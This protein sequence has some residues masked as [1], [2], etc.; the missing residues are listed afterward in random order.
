MVASTTSCAISKTGSDQTV[1]YRGSII[2]MYYNRQAV[3]TYKDAATT[4]YRTANP[5]LQL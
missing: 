5:R 4:V 2:S 1:N 3:G